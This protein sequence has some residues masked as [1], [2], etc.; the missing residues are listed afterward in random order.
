MKKR[1]SRL[2]RLPER[3]R[4]TKTTRLSSSEKAQMEGSLRNKIRKTPKKTTME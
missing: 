1:K 4:M 3:R 2:D